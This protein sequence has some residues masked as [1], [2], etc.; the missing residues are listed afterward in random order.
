MGDRSAEN[1]AAKLGGTS[2]S[3][4]LQLSSENLSLFFFL[5]EVLETLGTGGAGGVVW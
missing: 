3:S 2:L 4:Y 1:Q 5:G